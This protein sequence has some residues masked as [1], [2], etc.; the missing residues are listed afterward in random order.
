[1]GEGE[2]PQGCIDYEA[3]VPNADRIRDANAGGND[4]AGLFYTGGT[5]GR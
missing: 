4:L 5:T 2:C 3:L 1:M